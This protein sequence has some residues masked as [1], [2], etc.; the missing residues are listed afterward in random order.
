[1]ATHADLYR[2]GENVSLRQAMTILHKSNI[3]TFIKI[4]II[5]IISEWKKNYYPLPEIISLISSSIVEEI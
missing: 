1:M 4:E 3:H 2:I 5:V